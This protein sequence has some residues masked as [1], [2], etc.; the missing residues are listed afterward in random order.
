VT[1][2]EVIAL[3]SVVMTGGVTPFVANR[4]ERARAELQIRRAREDELRSV[5]E[6]AGVKLTES[7]IAFGDWNKVATLTQQEFTA[8]HADMGQLVKN[9]DR[10]AVRLGSGALEVRL[11]KQ[12]YDDG[13]VKA[14]EALSR[15]AAGQPPAPGQVRM[16]LEA[17]GDAQ[18]QF[19][20]AASVRV[21]PSL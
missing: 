3:V 15:K 9:F 7:V 13:I 21:G 6:H 16:A 11:Y 5:L 2:G 20:D 4:M 1:G 8:M 18:E 12:A 17:A 19:Y 14:Y 10:L